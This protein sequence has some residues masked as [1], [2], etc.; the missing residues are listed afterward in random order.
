MRTLISI[1]HSL[2]E[3]TIII[4]SGLLKIEE[5]AMTPYTFPE[6]QY[7]MVVYFD[8]TE[9]STCL[10]SHLYDYE[11]FAKRFQDKCLTIL[12]MSPPSDERGMVTHLL[13]LHHYSFIVLLDENHRFEKEN[14]GLPEDARF[15]AFFL[16][17]TNR[18]LVIGDP[19]VYPSL[20]KIIEKQ[21]YEE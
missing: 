9:C 10:V 16:D 12:L 11:L 6:A 18:P 3:R 4:P 21:F 5:N 20:L 15:H 2:K 8:S 14:P 7:K 17:K 1:V 13:S 19:I